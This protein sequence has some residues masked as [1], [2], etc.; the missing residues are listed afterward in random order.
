MRRT[1]S[2]LIPAWPDVAPQTAEVSGLQAVSERWSH[3]AVVLDDPA[4]MP[5][6]GKK[7]APCPWCAIAG[8]L[9]GKLVASAAVQIG[10]LE[11][12]P[13]S[14]ARLRRRPI[15]IATDIC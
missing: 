6:P 11:T 4:G 7:D 1:F 5:Q 14:A 9:A 15:R 12:N 10:V 8:G 3:G 2:P 13:A